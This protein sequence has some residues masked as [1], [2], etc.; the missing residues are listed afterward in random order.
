MADLISSLGRDI[1]EANISQPPAH[2]S[3]PLPVAANARW[4]EKLLLS[5]AL[6]AVD[7]GMVLLG[8]RLAY[9]LRFEVGFSDTMLLVTCRRLGSND[10]M[11]FAMKPPKCG[12]PGTRSGWSL[13]GREDPSSPDPRHAANRRARI[14]ILGSELA[15]W[16]SGRSN[17]RAISSVS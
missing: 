15:T 10:L 1:E 13:L 2:L 17:A 8:F 14:L 16:C 12:G 11:R 7:L 5:I 4:A 9:A 3:G 6:T